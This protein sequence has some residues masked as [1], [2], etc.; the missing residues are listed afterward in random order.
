MNS[1]QEQKPKPSVVY[2]TRE[3]VDTIKRFN[4]RAEDGGLRI[5]SRHELVE[6]VDRA[7]ARA[8]MLT[9]RWFGLVI[10]VLPDG[11]AHS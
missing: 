7:D 2:V 5:G 11:I 6:L 4:A 9:G 8:D 3:Q 10:G 1:L